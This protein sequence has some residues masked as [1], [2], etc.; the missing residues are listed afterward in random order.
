MRLCLA[1]FY[2]A[3]PLSAHAQTPIM[4]A[5]SEALFPSGASL[6]IPEPLSSRPARKLTYTIVNVF[7][8]DTAAF[9]EGLL[10]HEGYLYESVGME[11]QSDVRKVDLKSGRVVQ[12]SVIPDKA[13]GEG[14]A[15]IGDKLIQLTFTEGRAFIYDFATMRLTGEFRYKGE[16]WGLTTD[17]KNLI[18]GDGSDALTFRDPAT[19]AA[20][21][22]IRVTL[23][24]RRLKN[25]NELEFVDGA[26]WA[27]IWKDHRILRIDPSSG[28][29]TGWL[30][31]GGLLN[32]GERAQLIE[33]V[34]DVLNG[35]AYDPA[36]GHFFV[37]GKCWPVL[38]EIKIDE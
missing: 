33:P 13:F 12:S 18:M 23:D 30:D 9:T 7:P 20:R 37:T 38:F 1:A 24:G 3:V 22:R 2:L 19:F 14:L 34:E 8:H 29:V 31:M 11:G 21:R 4:P 25:I 15:L 35:I 28:R 26:I 36:S 6:A 5:N 10:W 16:G 27:N 17:G 32:D